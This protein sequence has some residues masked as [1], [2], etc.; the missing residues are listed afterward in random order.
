MTTLETVALYYDAW[1]TKQGGFSDVPLADDFAFTGPV[2]SL[3]TDAEK[4]LDPSR[5]SRRS[6]ALGRSPL[7]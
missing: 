7:S 3:I 6:R 1:Q 2:A 5:E 4:R